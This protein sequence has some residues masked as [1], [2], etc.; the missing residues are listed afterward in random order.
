MAASVAFR[1][2]RPELCFCQRGYGRN[3]AKW[4]FSYRQPLVAMFLSILGGLYEQES[5]LNNGG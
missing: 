5:M 2:F 1:W 4:Y 3:P